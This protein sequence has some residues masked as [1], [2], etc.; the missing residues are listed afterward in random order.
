MWSTVLMCGSW[1]VFG[2]MTCFIAWAFC[3]MA[4][5]RSTHAPDDSWEREA[6]LAP[7]VLHA[8][9][10]DPA[11]RGRLLQIARTARSLTIDEAWDRFS[12]QARHSNDQTTTDSGALSLKRFESEK[13]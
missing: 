6:D 12:A 3:S 7:I 8:D 13:P 4:S 9:Y 11:E 10:L 2:F 1:Y 5:T